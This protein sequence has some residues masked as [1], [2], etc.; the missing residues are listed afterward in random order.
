MVDT[1]QLSL[2]YIITFVGVYALFFSIS[3]VVNIVSEQTH[4]L[5]GTQDIV[6]VAQSSIGY[7]GFNMV[8]V[9]LLVLAI[10]VII[11]GTMFSRFAF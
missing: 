2:G 1:K 10:A 5:I 4:D 3:L 6:T 9:A 11:S 7:N 8:T